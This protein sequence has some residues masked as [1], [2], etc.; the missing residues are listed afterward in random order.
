MKQKHYL[1]FLLTIV[2]ALNA[3]TAGAQVIATFAGTGANGYTGDDTLATY[4]ELSGPSG[5]AVDGPGN[6]YIADRNNNVVRKVSTTGIIT[7]FAG[8][9][10]AG[11]SGNGGAATAAKL[12]QPYSVATDAAGNVYISDHGNNVVR[13]VNTTSGIINTYAGNGTAGFVGDTGLASLAELNGPQGIATD[14]AGNLYIADAVNGIVRKVNTFG[15]ISTIAGNHTTG[16]SGDN[17]AA[18]SASLH[19]PSGV[20][21]DASGNV[22][23]A[24]VLN[25]VVRKVTYLTG[26]ITTI[27]GN[28]TMGGTGDGGAATSAQLSFPS[29]VSLDMAGSLYIAD[30]GNNKIRRVDSLGMISTFAGSGTA[31]YTGD[32][33][34]P[35]NAEL[36]A[37][38][39]VYADGWMRIY[40]PDYNS[41]VV[42]IV[43][44]GSAGVAAT[45][46]LSAGIKTYPNPTAGMFTVEIPAVAGNS[47]ITVND[48]LGN[49]VA[50]NYT[51][52]QRSTVDLRNMPAG[53]YIVKVVSGNKTYT[54][55]VEIA[56]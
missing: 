3:P 2:F 19:S 16:Y 50:T 18:I 51:S 22:Y 20:A 9:G 46:A 5:I 32:Y 35:M 29:S 38:N 56:K 41:N 17:G 13:V 31:G 7:T 8:T 54:G 1:L 36:S 11:Y 40:I 15:K 33:G 39:A 23:I 28:N 44:Q 25:H 43:R 14:N 45:N 12:N 47:M 53:N 55:K 34:L 37:P 21:V 49:V 48:V 6:V 24:D 4:A 26:I 27:A 30:Q 42:R 10:T 52:V